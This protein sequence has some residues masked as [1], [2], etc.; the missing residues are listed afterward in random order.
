MAIV[1]LKNISGIHTPPF[2]YNDVSNVEE[3]YLSGRQF[4]K[5]THIDRS[6]KKRETVC[7]ASETISKFDYQ[8]KSPELKTQADVL[9]AY[10]AGRLVGY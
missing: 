9:S 1:P 4:L 5:F 7:V 3:V 8:N 2:W 10:K 6:T